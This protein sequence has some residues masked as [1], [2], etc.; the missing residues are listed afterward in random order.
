MTEYRKATPAE[1]I[2]ALDEVRTWA[3][4]VI[5]DMRES[6]GGDCITYEGSMNDVES[7]REAIDAAEGL[8]IVGVRK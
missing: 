6:P 1:L 8:Q 5:D 4:I 3:K 7:L 2:R